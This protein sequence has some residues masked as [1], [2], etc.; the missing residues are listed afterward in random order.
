MSAHW[1]NFT[2]CFLCFRFQR[3]H[4][5]SVF[6]E[7]SR[8]LKYRIKC[9][10]K[11]RVQ[12]HGRPQNDIL[13]RQWHHSHNTEGGRLCVSLQRTARQCLSKLCRNSDQQST[14]RKLFPC[15]LAPRMTSCPCLCFVVFIFFRNIIF[16]H[17][18]PRL[19]NCIHTFKCFLFLRWS[20][21]VAQAAVFLSP[22]YWGDRHVPSV[23]GTLF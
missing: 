17:K 4:F 5:I 10:H 19:L 18:Y 23:I 14:S 20:D 15:V 3:E 9:L 1:T 11:Y 21:N 6:K 13:L 7:L 8:F 2:L 12:L 22:K 16:C